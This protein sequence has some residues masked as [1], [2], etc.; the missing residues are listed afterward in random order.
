[1]F[2]L[3]M[4]ALVAGA[5]YRGEFEDASRRADEVKKS[6][7]KIILF[8]DEL[9]TIVGAGQAEGAMD[10]G[11]MLKPMLARGE[12]HCIGATTLDEYRKYIEKDAALERRF[13]PVM[14]GEPT[15]EDTI[16]ILRGL[17]E[18]YEVHHG[19]TINDARSWPPQRC[20]TAI[21]P[22]VSCP[23]RPS[24]WWTRP[25][26]CAW[27]STRM[28]EEM[29]DLQR[30][31]SPSCRSRRGA[32]EGDDESLQGAP[33]KLRKN[34]RLPARRVRSMKARWRTRRTP[35]AD[36]QKL[37]RDRRAREIERPRAKATGKAPSSVRRAP[38]CRSSWKP[39]EDR[40]REEAGRHAA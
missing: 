1:M 25:A 22:T 4:G 19:V 21:S 15:V 9:H 11:N 16:S 37:E 20:P 12:L 38:S 30:T 24:T 5:K 34:G 2:S 28:P 6:E 33:A 13:Q 39:S 31:A 40:G 8:I 7:G 26:P 36:V 14:V 10:A 35:S 3:D 18:R 17:K 23:T 27:R 29:D 32:E